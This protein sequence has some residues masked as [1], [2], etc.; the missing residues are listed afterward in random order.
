MPE[1][2]MLAAIRQEIDYNTDAFEKIISDKTFKNLFGSLSGEKLARPP[3]G[4]DANNPAIE[5]LKHKSFLAEMK[6]D[7]KSIGNEAIF[8][9]II[10]G[11]RAMQPLV[12]FLQEAHAS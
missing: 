8:K 3:K 2:A 10:Q 11:F 7:E 9:S 6:L 12:A 5:Y 1:A 4:Y